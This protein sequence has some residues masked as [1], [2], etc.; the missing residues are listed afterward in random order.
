MI[1]TK[2]GIIILI[3]TMMI[4]S[5]TAYAYDWNLGI[6]SIFTGINTTSLNVTGGNITLSSTSG[7]DGGARFKVGSFTRDIST[8]SGTQA[9]TGIGFKPSSISF[10]AVVSNTRMMSIGFDDATNHNA[11]YDS[12]AGVDLYSSITTE[13]IAL[14][15][16]AGNSYSGHVSTFDSD[17]FT[18]SWTKS[19]TITGTATIMYIAYR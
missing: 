11:I 7:I 5:S 9:V 17:G 1:K 15:L 2:N 10:N 6:T 13:S 16:T 14:D 4:L 8:A 3:M 12:T 18:M 19:G